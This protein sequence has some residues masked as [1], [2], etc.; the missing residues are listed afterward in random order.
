MIKSELTFEFAN[1][2]LEK[3][4]IYWWNKDVEN[5]TSLFKYTTYY[6][7]TPFMKP[8]TSFDEI[9]KEWQHIKNQDIKKIEFKILA[10]DKN[11]LIVEWLF[12]GD[13]T[14]Y[15]GIY[16]IKFNENLDCIYFRSWEMEE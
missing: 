4:R 5:A 10:I 14:K 11:V 1:E 2:W 12:E 15:S 9:K 16:E 13:I 8:Y 3:L 6:Q 7:E